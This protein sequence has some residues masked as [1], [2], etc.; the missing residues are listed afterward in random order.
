L[1]G[2]I[3][4]DYLPAVTARRVFTSLNFILIQC[5]FFALLSFS[6]CTIF[7]PSIF[8]IGVQ[9]SYGLRVQVMVQTTYDTSLYDERTN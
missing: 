1:K 4:V 2:F 5:I 7:L 8:F 9:N 3:V 6:P